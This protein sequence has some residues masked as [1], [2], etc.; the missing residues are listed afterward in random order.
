MGDFEHGVWFVNLAPLSDSAMVPSAIA[1][2]LGLQ[3][4][5]RGLAE[6]LH[7]FIM[8]TEADTRQILILS[9]FDPTYGPQTID[10]IA[11]PLSR[12]QQETLSS[13]TVTLNVWYGF[14]IDSKRFEA[15]FREYTGGKRG[16]MKQVKTFVMEALLYRLG[17]VKGAVVQFV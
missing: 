2:V 15:S 6:R 9:F 10:F 4:G 16:R 14:A 3:Q 12:P 7:E 17:T 13:G 8:T 5:A 1:H 11:K